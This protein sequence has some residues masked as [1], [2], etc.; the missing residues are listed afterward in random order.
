MFKV[1]TRYTFHVQHKS[2]IQLLSVESL[3]LY[4]FALI[5]DLLLR[6]SSLRF[7]RSQVRPSFFLRHERVTLIETAHICS[8]RSFNRTRFQRERLKRHRL[9]TRALIIEHGC[10]KTN[11]DLTGHLKTT[12]RTDRTTKQSA[13]RRE[14]TVMGISWRQNG[15]SK[16]FVDP[17]CLIA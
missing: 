12:D 8:F 11:S 6:F 15:C 5:S 2:L 17:T 14:E 7:A 9:Y 4:M 13:H 10:D 16:G 1:F 3:T